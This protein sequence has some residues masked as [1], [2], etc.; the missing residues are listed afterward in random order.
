MECGARLAFHTITNTYL[1]YYELRET[2]TYI[3]SHSPQG[4]QARLLFKLVSLIYGR[5]TRVPRGPYS[6]LTQVL[7]AS[8]ALFRTFSPHSAHV[9]SFHILYCALAIILASTSSLLYPCARYPVSDTHLAHGFPSPF[10]AVHAKW[11]HVFW[12]NYPVI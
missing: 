4:P 1:L 7:R 10:S 11:F 9:L 6:Q 2:P 8:F 3:G 12:I 5:R